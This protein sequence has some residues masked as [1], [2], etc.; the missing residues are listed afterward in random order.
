MGE[1]PSVGVAALRKRALKGHA[2][3]RAEFRVIVMS[4]TGA[5]AWDIRDG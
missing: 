3:T 2:N 1:P 5:E 4:Q